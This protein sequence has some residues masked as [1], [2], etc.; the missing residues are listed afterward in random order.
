MRFNS[1]SRKGATPYR[2]Y[3]KAKPIV[4]IHAPVR[5]RLDGD[6]VLFDANPV[7]IHAPVRERRNT[8]MIS[9]ITA[10]FNSRSRE[11]ATL[12]ADTTEKLAGFNSR[13]PEGATSLNGS[14]MYSVLFQFTLP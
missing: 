14:F 1:R 2:R 6:V 7:S 11:G 12:P 4:S 10:G 3:G 9:G 5:E 8:A 13:S